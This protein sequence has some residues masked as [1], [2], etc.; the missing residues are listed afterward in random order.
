LELK[1]AEAAGTVAFRWQVDEPKFAMPVRVG[2]QGHWQIIRPT[3]E[4]QTMKTAIKKDEFG[5]ATD[6]YYL[7][8]S[9]L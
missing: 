7:E 9:K 3:T 5:V 6:L 8:V 2:R 4:W 1:F